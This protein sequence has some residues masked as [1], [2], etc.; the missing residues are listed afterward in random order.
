MFLEP[1]TSL[2]V[3]ESYTFTMEQFVDPESGISDLSYRLLMQIS[4]N[5]GKD[6]RQLFQ[7]L[8]DNYY[9]YVVTSYILIIY[10]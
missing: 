8:P 7:V 3:A 1:F 4:N 6:W 5:I 10:V 9:K 2:P